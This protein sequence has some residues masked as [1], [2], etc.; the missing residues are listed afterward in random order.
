M[1]SFRLFIFRRWL[2][3]G[4]SLVAAGASSVGCGCA[5]V[6]KSKISCPQAAELARATGR[7]PLGNIGVSAGR[8]LLDCFLCVHAVLG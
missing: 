7:W 8:L 6:L 1:L 5:G 3:P 2:L 4:F